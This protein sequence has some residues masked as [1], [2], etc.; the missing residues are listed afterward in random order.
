MEKNNTILYRYTSWTR[1]RQ[2]EATHEVSGITSNNYVELELKIYRVIHFDLK[3]L[4]DNHIVLFSERDGSIQK[5][6]E[7]TYKDIPTT[8][9]LTVLVENVEQDTGQGVPKRSQVRMKVVALVN[10]HKILHSATI[11][12]NLEHT[13]YSQLME[14]IKNIL[15]DRTGQTDSFFTLMYK[16]TPLWSK[17]YIKLPGETTI[18]VVIDPN[19]KATTHFD[20][21]RQLERNLA[22]IQDRLDILEMNRKRSL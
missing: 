3:L 4:C 14:S 11:A 17:E 12:G 9:K 13:C 15:Q 18:D 7:S 5:L 8:A 22:N 6:S 19:A 20:T 21:T 2:R 16:N 1:G 10:G